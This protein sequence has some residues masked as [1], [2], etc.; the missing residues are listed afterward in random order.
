MLRN[1]GQIKYSITSSGPGL[2]SRLGSIQAAIL[3]EKLKLLNKKIDNQIKLYT[4][5]QIFLLIYK[6]LVFHLLE[7]NLEQKMQYQHLI[8]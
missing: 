5:Y 6:L 3:L 2:N 1:H 4:K 7:I 8:Y